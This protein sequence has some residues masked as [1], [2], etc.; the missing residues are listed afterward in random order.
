MEILQ[1]VSV[2]GNLLVWIPAGLMKYPQDTARTRRDLFAQVFIFP[3]N[4]Q[5]RIPAVTL[6]QYPMPTPV[7]FAILQN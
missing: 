6:F 7:L 5:S 4:D 1:R 3:H 2:S